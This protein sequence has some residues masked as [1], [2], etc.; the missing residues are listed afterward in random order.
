M[1]ANYIEY[2]Q[3]KNYNYY[4]DLFLI[5]FNSLDSTDLYQRSVM[6]CHWVIVF[7]P[8]WYNLQS[9][10]ITCGFFLG[11]QKYWEEKEVNIA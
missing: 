6:T 10:A 3:M 9:K 1:H 11:I 8:Q 4:R 2:Q 7:I 5:T